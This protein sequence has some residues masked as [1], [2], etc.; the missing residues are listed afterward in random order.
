MVDNSTANASVTRDATSGTGGTNWTVDVTVCKLSPDLTVKDFKVLFNGVVNSLANFTKNSQTLITYSGTA[1]TVSTAVVVQRDTP[2]TRV[3]ELLIPRAKVSITNWE[4]EFNLLHR[5]LN[6]YELNGV[7]Q[8]SIP[9]FGNPSN[10]PFGV[11][12]SGDATQTATRNTLYNKFT[13]DTALFTP[14]DAVFGVAW[15]GDTTKAPSK[16]AVYD[17]IIDVETQITAKVSDTAFGGSWDATTTIAPSQ[18]AVYD[19]FISVDAAIN[20]KSNF[21]YF[22]NGEPIVNQRPNATFVDLTTVFGVDRFALF[23]SDDGGTVAAAT[24]TQQTFTPGQTAVP[25]EPRNY[26]RLNNT[27]QGSSLGTV[28]YHELFSRIEDVRTLAGQSVTLSFWARSTIASKSI[29]VQFE[30]NFGSGGSGSTFSTPQHYTLSSTWTKFTY[31]VTLASIN[32]KTVGSASYLNARVFLQAGSLVLSPSFTWQGTGDTEFA[33]FKL[34]LGS[35]ATPITRQLIKT[36]YELCERYLQISRVRWQG[37]VTN[38]QVYVHTGYFHTAMRG[39]PTLTLSG[40]S[41]SNMG[42]VAVNDAQFNMWAIQ[43]TATATGSGFFV[44]D[45]TASAEL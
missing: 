8:T 11:S 36:E 26:L 43:A 23:A 30:Q 44:T 1:L 19:K 14:S 39:T 22:L 34:E 21:N 18:N 29:A 13:S 12:W 4:A 37:D 32:G 5:V 28:S 42:T 7:G 17:K 9:T 31:Q 3:A 20:A 35:V 15:N 33:D 40:T 38:G 2:I 10:D 16:N 6:E 45:I 41:T 25:G 27:T 24:L